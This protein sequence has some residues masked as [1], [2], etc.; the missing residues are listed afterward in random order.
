MQENF[1]IRLLQI[2]IPEYR[3]ALYEGV[4]KRYPGRFDIQSS[5]FRDK[6]SPLYNINGVSCDYS[7][8]LIRLGPFF[9][10]TGLSLKGLRKGDVLIVDGNL[11]NLAMMF[12]IARARLKGLRVVWWAQHWTSGTKMWRARLRIFLSKLL[13]DVYLCYTKSGIEFL[14]HYGY[15]RGRLFATENTIEQTS[16]KDAL[17]YWTIDKLNE[18]KRKNNIE[19]GDVLL[20][21][22]VLREKVRLPQLIKALSDERLLKRNLYLVVIGDGPEK[23]K[24]VQLAHSLKMTDRILWIPASRV[25]MELAPWFLSANLFVY[26]GAIGLSILHSFSY[27]LPVV[28]HENAANQMPEFEAMEDGKTGLVFK[29]NDISDM[30]DKIVY[31]LDNKDESAGMGRYA[32]RLAFERYSMDNMI[33]N[34]CAV[35]EAAYKRGLCS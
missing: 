24:C 18:F 6:D 33:N 28:T 26:P 34:Y 20:L 31:L 1:K 10:E 17:N 14:S 19:G 30:V 2:W 12:A 27:A 8:R 16:I 35:I 29:E 3:L 23:Q 21:C 9:W 22:G 11:R 32:Q 13:S 4:G 7:H 15:P 5:Q 25:Q